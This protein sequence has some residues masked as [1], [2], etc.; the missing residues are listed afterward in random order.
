V[1]TA[2]LALALAAGP[3]LQP[4]FELGRSKN[5]NIVV[6]SA[7]VLPDGSL[8]PQAPVDAH[9]VMKAQDGRS[10]PLSELERKLAYGIAATQSRPGLWSVTLN[11]VRDRPFTLLHLSDGWHAVLRIGGVPSELTRVFVQEK[12]KLDVPEVQWCEL[13][14]KSVADGSETHERL[15]PPKK[16]ARRRSDGDSW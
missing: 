11:A 8:D 12:E 1:T 3:A 15:L 4:M 10:Q 6:Y 2:A 9:W 16:S 14:G 13:S 7:R 5:A